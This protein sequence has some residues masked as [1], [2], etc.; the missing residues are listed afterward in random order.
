MILCNTTCSASS[1]GSLTDVAP[2]QSGG[3]VGQ[4][5]D[6]PGPSDTHVGGDVLRR[7]YQDRERRERPGQGQAVLQVATAVLDPDHLAGKT[8]RQRSDAGV[9]ARH[10]AEPGN[11]VQE[12]LVPRIIDPL[13]PLCQRC[14]D[15]GGARK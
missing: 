6:R 9:A 4:S 11:V 2:Q 13:E 12:Q 15:A 8:S 3:D 1:G 7:A 5:V 10:T 14:L